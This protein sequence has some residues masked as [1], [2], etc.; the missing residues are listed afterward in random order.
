[1]KK[2]IGIISF[3]LAF[4]ISAFILP[5]PL[6]AQT[7]DKEKYKNK[8]F[9][10]WNNY[11]SNDRVSFKEKR[12]FTVPASG[13]ITVDSNRNGGIS[14]K[15]ENRSDI[16]VRACVNTMGETEEA[17]KALAGRI[18]I[19]TG[20]V[21]K[22]DSDND[23]DWSVSFEVLVP[24]N[25]NLKL[26]AHNGGIAIKSVDGDVEFETTNGGVSLYDMA[27]D[28]RGRTT[29][30]GVNVSLT[31][32]SWKGRGLDVVTTNGG[33][34]LAMPEGYAA[35]IET[36]TTNGG[37]NSDIPA[38]NITTEDV[39]GEWRSRSKKIVTSLNGGGAPI[40][41]MTT[42]GGIKIGSSADNN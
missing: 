13:S 11:S 12:E 7:K 17:A 1:M 38:L 28:V 35:N 2:S 5:E 37:F 19:E 31:G 41:V 36:G 23:R 10:S 18:R 32:N 20:S 30:G 26:T 42:N 33:V 22:A 29:N 8:E 3:S 9:C 15:G 4:L 6:S 34:K 27:G 21:I 40:K 14:V 25:T 16:L 24:R 39:K